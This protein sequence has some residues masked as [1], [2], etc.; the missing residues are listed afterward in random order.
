MRLC[1]YFHEWTVV[2]CKRNVRRRSEKRRRFLA[3]PI[4]GVRVDVVEGETD[5]GNGDR[6]EN[7]VCAQCTV[8]LRTCA[9]VLVHGRVV[10]LSTPRTPFIARFVLMSNFVRA[11]FRRVSAT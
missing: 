11:V 6:E 8:W 7:F 9:L 1:G 10:L 2:A 3:R 5:E 4:S